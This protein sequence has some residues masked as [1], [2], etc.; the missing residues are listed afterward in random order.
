MIRRML[1]KAGWRTA[2]AENGL[3]GLERLTEE[4]P[5]AILLD[6]LMPEMDGFEFLAR[7]RNKKAWRSISR[8]AVSS[9]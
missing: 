8:V 1:N 3:V 9:P 2:E 7:L 4:A 5:A 6:L